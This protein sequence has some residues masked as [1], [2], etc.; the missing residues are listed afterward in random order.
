[1]VLTFVQNKFTKESP[2]LYVD[3]S[4]DNNDEHDNDGRSNV[5][6][7]DQIYVLLMGNMMSLI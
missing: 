2:D 6:K 7:I 5:T 1:M 3:I 4:D